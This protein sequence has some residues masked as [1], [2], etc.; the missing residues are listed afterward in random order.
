VFDN[1]YTG[2]TLAIAANV[3]YDPRSTFNNGTY[4]ELHPDQPLMTILIQ[5]SRKSV[6]SYDFVPVL[7]VTDIK[8]TE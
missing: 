5:G 4:L 6:G 3:G 1:T 7:T 8:Y 2:H